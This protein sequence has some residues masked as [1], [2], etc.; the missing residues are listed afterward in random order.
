MLIEMHAGIDKARVH[1]PD[2]ILGRTKGISI[3]LFVNTRVSVDSEGGARQIFYFKSLWEKRERLTKRQQGLCLR[4]GKK[5][6]R[7]T[8]PIFDSF[9]SYYEDGISSVVLV[10]QRRCDWHG[11]ITISF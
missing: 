9:V 4:L 2:K 10:L 6:Y 3:N 7:C 11:I 5:S 8:G 1:E